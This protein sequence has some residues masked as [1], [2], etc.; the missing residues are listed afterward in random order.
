MK[1]IF[2][3]IIHAK[4]AICFFVILVLCASNLSANS[5]TLGGNKMQPSQTVNGTITDHTGQGLAGVSVKVKGTNIT[6]VTHADGKYKISVPQDN[7][8]LVFSYVGFKT[9]E[10]TASSRTVIDI[11]LLEDSSNLGGVVIV[12]YGSQ[13]RETLTTSISKLDNRTLENVPYTNAL[14]ALQGSVSGVL[15]QSVTGQPG[16]PPRVVL[17]GGASIN[18]NVS[19]TGNSP[20]YLIDG[21]IRLNLAD[22]ASEDIESFQVLKD[23]AATSIYGSRATNGVILVTTKSGKAGTTKISYSYDLTRADEGSRALAYTSVADYVY[24]ARMG[25]IMAIPK[26]GAAAVTTRLATPAGYGTG[27]DLSKN[28]AFTTQYLT[29][30][31]QFKLDGGWQSIKDPLDP[32]KTIIFDETNF[33]RLRMKTAISHNLMAQKR[34]GLMLAYSYT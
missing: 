24:Y 9:Q 18:Q 14:F 30:A 11:K 26:I 16:Q 34:Q 20:L 19:V 13:S 2:T 28:T 17:R 1:L 8:I 22:V 23:A 25:N 33:Q 32:T 12:S 7:S 6:A 31:N 10:I 4:K 29:P 21:V 3:K 15:V 27:N 5:N